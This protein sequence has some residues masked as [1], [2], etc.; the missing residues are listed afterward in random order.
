VSATVQGDRR[1]PQAIR[2]VAVVL[3]IVA[4]LMPLLYADGGEAGEAV[5]FL[6]LLGGWEFVPWGL[7]AS[8]FVG[9]SAPV[10]A[11]TMAAFVVISVMIYA[12]ADESSTGAIAILFL[13]AYLLMVLGLVVLVAAVASGVRRR[14]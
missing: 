6:V 7:V 5:L 3:G 2:S 8:R 1:G 13:P 4:A 9:L 11:G 10:R 14:G 12:G